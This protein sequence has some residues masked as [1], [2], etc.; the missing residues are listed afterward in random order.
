MYTPFY[1]DG[2]SLDALFGIALDA[3]GAQVQVL[4]DD[5]IFIAEYCEDCAL[6]F[7]FGVFAIDDLNGVSADYVPSFGDVEG[8]RFE[9]GAFLTH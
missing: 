1:H 9:F 7:V 4:D 8:C 3:F 2:L 5:A 6:L